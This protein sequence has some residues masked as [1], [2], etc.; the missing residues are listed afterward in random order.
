MFSAPATRA[1]VVLVSLG[2]DIELFATEDMLSVWGSG[3]DGLFV[4]VE[5]GLGLEKGSHESGLDLVLR[6]LFLVL[7]QGVCAV[8]LGCVRRWGV[9]P[10]TEAFGNGGLLTLSGAKALSAG[11]GPGCS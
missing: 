3:R 8:S 11:L 5:C 10:A 7:T 2:E 6:C 4:L 9:E 1:L